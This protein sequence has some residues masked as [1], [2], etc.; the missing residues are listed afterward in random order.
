[1]IDSL[2]ALL[3]MVSGTPLANRAAADVE[4]PDSRERAFVLKI[5]ASEVESAWRI[6]RE[7]LPK[8]NRWPVVSTFWT[9]GENDWQ[10]MVEEADFFC[11]FEY[12]HESYPSDIS[13]QGL[14]KA[15]EEADP[16]LMISDLWRK[17][18]GYDDISDALEF[19][20]PDTERRYGNAP[21]MEQTQNA[22]L[23]G[24]PLTTVSQLERWLF[25]W[26]L[27]HPGDGK[28]E[29]ARQDWYTQDP[30]ALIFLPTSN[31]WETLAYMHWFAACHYGSEY[32]VA[33]L[34]QWAD[35]YGAELVAH[36][37]TMLQ[38]FVTNPPANADDAWRVANEHD[39][40][41]PCT[42]GPAAITVRHHA[43]G[44]INHGRWFLHER[45]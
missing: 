14:V 20:L 35:E 17:R 26:E 42:L 22:R 30:S 13:P 21:S 9:G 18:D 19:H 31:S 38:F 16:Q 6:A 45:P 43:L 40:V 5:S 32:Y 29:E 23:A 4:V 39:L 34:K 41:A 24:E 7:L 25:E 33:L 36:Y 1:M 15:A 27:K 44:L 2:D 10:T 3:E 11:R 28:P 12:E 37:G 8:T